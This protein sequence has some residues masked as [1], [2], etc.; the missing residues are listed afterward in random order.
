MNQSLIYVSFYGKLRYNYFKK[1]KLSI[2]RTG[3]SAGLSLI[4]LVEKEREVFVGISHLILFSSCKS[5][6]KYTN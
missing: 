3:G 5:H 4:N 6:N 1:S 2:Q